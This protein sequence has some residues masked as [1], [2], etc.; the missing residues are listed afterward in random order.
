M[1]VLLVSVKSERS[2]GGVAV[3]T[4]QYLSGCEAGGIQCD[5][6][7]TEA[8]GKIAVNVTAKRNL[9]DEFIRTRR[10][11]SELSIDLKQNHYDVAHL[12]TNIGF[13]GIIRDYYVAKNIVR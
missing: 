10:I 5:V 3:W 4:N 13:L 8:V 9:K 11:N 2:K 7:N 1:K 12:N 6:V